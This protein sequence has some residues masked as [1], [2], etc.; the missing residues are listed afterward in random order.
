MRFF[1]C[2]CV[3]VCLYMRVSM[4]I[5]VCKY[6]YTCS[7]CVCMCVSILYI[8]THVICIYK[9][10]S[11]RDHINIYIYILSPLKRIMRI[12]ILFISLSEPTKHPSNLFR[13]HRRA[14]FIPL[15][16]PPHL[17]HPLLSTHSIYITPP[18]HP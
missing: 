4:F 3:Y 16:T 14:N 18:C 5:Y 13:C 8:C 12:F 6:V 15:E 10:T 17:L 7:K 2:I 11:T 1:T 9:H